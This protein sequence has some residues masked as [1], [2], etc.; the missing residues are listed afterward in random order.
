M[1][2]QDLPA[3]A[4][5]GSLFRAF[6]VVTGFRASARYHFENKKPNPLSMIRCTV[7]PWKPA[8]HY[9]CITTVLRKS[10]EFGPCSAFSSAA[11]L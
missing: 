1:K 4:D 6:L 8:H 2:P 9:D 10:A 3:A 7:R 11:P 5:L